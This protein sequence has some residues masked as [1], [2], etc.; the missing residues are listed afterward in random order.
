MYTWCYQM[1]LHCRLAYATLDDPTKFT[2]LDERLIGCV[3]ELP[4][5]AHERSAWVRHVLERDSAD[6]DGY[7]ADVLPAGP[8]GAA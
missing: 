6:V 3:W 8:V 1:V 5:L 7:L 4:A 2:P